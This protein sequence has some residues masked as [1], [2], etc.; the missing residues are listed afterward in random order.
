MTSAAAP[1]KI[2]LCGEHAVV[3]G[4]PAVAI[5][6]TQVTARATVEPRDAVG[7]ELV[8]ADIDVV[9][10]PFAEG[11]EAQYPLVE[12]VRAV[13]AYF[14]RT[15]LPPLT[16]TLQ[17]SIPI[18]SGLGSGAASAAAIIRALLR[19]FGDPA[20]NELVSRLT[21][22]VEKQFHGT[23]SGIDNTV[24]TFQ[25]PVYF[26]RRRPENITETFVVSEPL[27]FLVADTGVRVETKA[28]VSDVR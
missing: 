11:I 27:I 25:Q 14:G 18:A 17:S 15:Q 20:S 22:S 21:Y 10:D 23:P 5:P 7:V 6:L 19:H 9:V 26:V 28:V 1:G 4:Y 8:L 2:I 24:V 3:Y 12:A 13:A 16:I